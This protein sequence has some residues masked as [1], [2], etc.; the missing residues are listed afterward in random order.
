MG[1][2]TKVLI[3]AALLAIGSGIHYF[4]KTN[5]GYANDAEEV[6]EFALHTQGVDV[7]FDNMPKKG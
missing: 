1:K 4:K 2:V 7:D 6:I 5:D 3:I